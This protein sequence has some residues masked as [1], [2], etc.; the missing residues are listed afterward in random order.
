MR[1]NWSV[2]LRARMIWGRVNHPRAE[3]SR[4]HVPRQLCVYLVFWAPDS[5]W[6]GGFI[7]SL[8]KF[9]KHQK[10]LVKREITPLQLNLF[11]WPNGGGR[12]KIRNQLWAVHKPIQG[13][14][15]FVYQQQPAASCN[16]PQLPLCK[17]M[18]FHFRREGAKSN[19]QAKQMTKYWTAFLSFLAIFT[20]RRL[21]WQHLAFYSCPCL[22]VEV[23]V[24]SF[25]VLRRCWGPE[26]EAMLTWWDHLCAGLK[27]ASYSVGR[28]MAIRKAEMTNSLNVR[29]LE[30]RQSI[31]A[32]Y[33][34]SGGL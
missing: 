28:P 1:V 30:A 24:L 20:P 17:T 7:F 11:H 21:P 19:V 34:P 13:T 27:M 10:D 15:S 5:S 32:T 4:Q 3:G 33:F 22:A 12:K 9:S 2:S 14:W 18:S 6:V 23:W 31:P 8:G 25:S 26:A 29:S 16:Q